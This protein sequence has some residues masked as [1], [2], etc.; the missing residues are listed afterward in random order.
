[1]RSSSFHI[2]HSFILAR[3]DVWRVLL[4]ACSSVLH[5]D[6]FLYGFRLSDS[7]LY[8][9]MLSDSLLYGLRK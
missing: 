3:G 2:L 1:M 7:L 4:H 6:V 9:L 5:C 8:G